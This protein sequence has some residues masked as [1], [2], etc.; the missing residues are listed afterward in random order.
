MSLL[1]VVL[2][3][4]GVSSYKFHTWERREL[5]DNNDGY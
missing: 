2:N 3:N 1:K 5:T 4:G